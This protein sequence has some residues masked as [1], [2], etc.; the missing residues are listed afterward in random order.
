LPQDNLALKEVVI[1]AKSKSGET[2]TS[3]VIDR[4]GLDH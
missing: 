1:T 4:A 3:Y 2:A